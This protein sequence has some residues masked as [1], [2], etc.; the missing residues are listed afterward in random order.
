LCRKAAR[1]RARWTNKALA[2]RLGLT[3]S[4]V[5]HYIERAP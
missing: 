2:A 1:A 3:M 4:Q 5:R